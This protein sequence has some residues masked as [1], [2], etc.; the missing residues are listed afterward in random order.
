MLLHVSHCTSHPRLSEILGNLI[1]LHFAQFV[2]FCMHIQ[3]YFFIH[4]TI[5]IFAYFYT[6]DTF[7]ETQ[8]AMACTHSLLYFTGGHF[9]K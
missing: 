8:E 9:E 1:C 3:I 2:Y 4:K 6:L 5:D 7:L